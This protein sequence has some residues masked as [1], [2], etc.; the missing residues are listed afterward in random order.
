MWQVSTRVEY[1]CGQ[2]ATRGA[3]RVPIIDGLSSSLHET[4]VDG[5]RIK[6]AGSAKVLAWLG[7]MEAA[8]PLEFGP[9]DGALEKRRDPQ[10]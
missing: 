8:A 9:S 3:F 2:P 1:A 6:H 5:N 7:Y 10:Q 4:H